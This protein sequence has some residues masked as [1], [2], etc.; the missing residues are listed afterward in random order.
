M[1]TTQS[2]RKKL[3]EV[4]LPLLKINYESAREKSGNKPGLPSTLHLWWARRPLAACRALIFASMVDDPSQCPDEFPTVET[5]LAERDRLFGLI[6][7]MVEWENSNDEGLY[8]EV[9]SEIA[10]SVAR[11]RGDAAPQ[12][13]E[14]VLKYL[15]EHAPTIYDPFA[16]GGSIPIEAQRLGM[17]SAGSDLN[18][19]AVLLTKA[20]IE[21]PTKCLDRDPINP[22]ADLVSVSEQQ[23]QKGRQTRWQGLAGL[24]DD[25]SFYGRWMRDQAF[26]RIGQYYPRVKLK[27]GSHKT[28][29]A[30][31]WA[32]N[33][34]CANPA[35]G[36]DM[37]LLNSFQ[38]SAKKNNT[39]WIRPI[40]DRAKNIISFSVQNH[41]VDVPSTGTVNRSG[42]RCIACG[43]AVKLA[44]VREQA[45]R[46][47]VGRQMTAIVAEGDRSRLFLSPTDEHIRIALEAHP[48]WRPTEP[49]PEKALGI[50][51]RGYGITQWHQFFTDRQLT[52]LSTLCDV[53]CDFE[54][55]AGQHSEDGEYIAVLKSYLALAI[56]RF[57]NS[58]STLARWDK[59]V[60]SV[61]TSFSRPAIPIVWDFAEVNPFSNSTKNWTDL[62]D[63]ISEVVRR[64]PRNVND[65][66]S[67]Q[68][69]AAGNQTKFSSPIYITDPPYYNNIGY[70]DLSDY[71][72]VWLRRVLRDTYSDLFAGMLTPKKE[73]IVAAPRFDNPSM[74]FEDSLSKT[75]SN[76]RDNCSKN[77]PSAV[78]YAYKQ[79]TKRKGGQFST[80]WE[81]MLN[82]V[83]S[84]GFQ[85]V[86]TWPMRTEL[87]NRP[88]S[89]GSNA[90]AS[91]VAI[92]I[93]PRSANAL[94]AT[95]QEFIQEL[96]T[97]LPSALDHLTR[98]SLVA[99]ADLRQSAIGPGME[100]YSKYNRIESLSGERVTVR[101]A[102]QLI[103]EVV[104]NYF[105]REEGSLD[106]PSRFCADW[107]R[108]H[109]YNEGLYDDAENIARAI[110]I[111]VSDVA[112][113]QQLVDNSKRGIIQLYP[114]FKY[115]P[116]RKPPMTD[117][118]AWEGCMRMAYHLDTSNE[119]GKGVVG[120]GE[121]GRRMAGNLDSIERLARIL[122]NH[123]DNL[124][125]PRNA[126]IYNQLVSEWQNILDA[127]QAPQT[128]TLV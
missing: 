104:G 56:G 98:G 122:Y 75:L 87:A 82:S 45:Q 95:R 7:R 108:S 103:N 44:Y 57:A 126:Y 127:T 113:Q 61:I 80:G 99:S 70:S 74:W 110:N 10:R 97:Q 58:C 123:Y 47:N 29:I 39:Y 28:I 62:L 91:S 84:S 50:S 109:G 90:L 53:L 116:D 96:E 14:Q 9:R 121:V 46:G 105:D 51:V 36:F 21:L 55:F 128:P 94:V 67:F 13:S 2:Y 31:L 15:R 63:G 125:Q 120:C 66:V 65:G 34:P 71:F 20:L 12:T 41:D 18:P 11:D 119:D 85:I 92:A 73:E 38:I 112:D 76:M 60:V 48:A 32:S 54:T 101:D 24:A 30:W 3:I 78:F 107:L 64:L 83:I 79:Q 115:D 52:I 17:I 8:E 68:A 93:R 89:I 23:H 117:M 19:I 106:S 43:N 69:D 59:T 72:Y 111:S 35:C 88:R 6:G 86:G 26:E 42:A 40:I 16:G 5:Q 27:D 33:V 114:V 1:P 102:L 22:K 100:I 4:G 77:Y 118:T 49:T 25:I 37:P 124:D 81:T